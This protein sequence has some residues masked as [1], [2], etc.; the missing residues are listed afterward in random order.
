MAA[1]VVMPTGSGKSAVLMLVLYLIRKQRVSIVTPSKMVRGQIAED[2]SKLRTLCI[3]N[4]FDMSIERP[5]VFELEHLCVEEYEKDSE[6]ADVI[7]ATPNCARS[8][9]ETKWAKKNIDLVEVDEAHHT[10]AKTWKQILVNL[11]EAA[12]VLFTATPF[13]LDRKELMGEIA[14]DYPLSK[15]YEDGIFGEIQFISVESGKDNDLRIAKRAEEILLNDRKI[16]Y[17]HCLMV[18][19]DTKINSQKLERLYED[20]TSLKLL[21]IDSSMSNSKINN[22]L[23]LLHSKKNRWDNLCRYAWR[24]V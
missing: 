16:G 22:V 6:Q 1:I 20:N 18:R 15:A 4:V 2:F 19:T 23:K 11:S 12:H 9:S 13:R 17:E 21:K 5:K 10:P 24:R 14:Y 8:L 7:I 3:A